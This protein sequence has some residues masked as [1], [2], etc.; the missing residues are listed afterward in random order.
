MLKTNYDHSQWLPTQPRHVFSKPFHFHATSICLHS[1][2]CSLPLR[3]SWASLL[4]LLISGPYISPFPQSLCMCCKLP[5]PSCCIFS[6]CL[7]F[8]WKKNKQQH[9]LPAVDTNTVIEIKLMLG[10]WPFGIS[11][12]FR[13]DLKSKCES[14]LWCQ[15]RL[16]SHVISSAC[17]ALLLYAIVHLYRWW[18]RTDS[19][20]LK[21]LRSLEKDH[22]CS[23]VKAR[24]PWWDILCSSFASNQES[25]AN[26]KQCSTNFAGTNQ[27]VLQDSIYS[28]K[29]A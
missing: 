29:K 5:S 21:T 2:N 18:I 14:R 20:S 23:G 22:L 12:P 15:L 16:H 24:F 3:W 19:T 17:Q 7:I 9:L 4:F 11:A 25:C 6:I 1:R 27:K 26:K 28:I 10:D 13:S 8:F